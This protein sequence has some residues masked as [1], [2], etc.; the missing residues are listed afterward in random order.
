MPKNP[1]LFENILMA[2]SILR[3]PGNAASLMQYISFSPP[4]CGGAVAGLE[5]VIL[6]MV[7]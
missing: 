3:G 1:L 2:R 4:V 5:Y 7:I 6:V